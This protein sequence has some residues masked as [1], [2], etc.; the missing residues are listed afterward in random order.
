MK[1]K[2]L[3][4]VGEVTGSCTWCILDSGVQFLVDCGSFQGWSS[5]L[6]NRGDFPFQAEDIRFVLLTHAHIDH[7]GRI[8]LLYKRGFRGKVYCTGATQ[9]LT[10]L[11]LTDT[12][13]IEAERAE[14][15]KTAPLFTKEDVSKI[16]FC[17]IKEHED[18]FKKPA[19]VGV[20][21]NF[22]VNFTRSSHLLGAAS[23]AISWGTGDNTRRIFFSGDVGNNRKGNSYQPLL[24][25]NH[26][27]H[28][29]MDYVVLESTYGARSPRSSDM[30]DPVKRIEA[31]K[32]VV[33]DSKYNLV[34]FP[35][36][37][38]QRTQD[39]LFDLFCALQYC[40]ADDSVKYRIVL[41]SPMAKTA[42]KIFKRHLTERH[43]QYPGIYLND[44][45]ARAIS[46]HY[47][48]EIDE[49]EIAGAIFDA[50]GYENDKLSINGEFVKN[51]GRSVSV[52]DKL[53]E[54]VPR[55]E[56]I[57]LITSSGMCQEGRIKGH[58]RELQY[59]ETALVLTGY[60]STHNGGLL[61][62]CADGNACDISNEELETSGDPLPIKD[63]QGAVFNLG[64]YY[65]GHADSEDLLRFLF[66]RA[67]DKG[68][69]E[70][71]KQVV[72]FLNHGDD[73]ARAQFKQLIENRVSQEDDMRTVGNV[74]I[75]TLG[76]NFYD[77]NK[78]ELVSESYEIIQNQRQIIKQL[79]RLLAYAR[80]T[81]PHKKKKAK[82]RRDAD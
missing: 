46:E 70:S 1:V 15:E 3:G 48:V 66:E 27:P 69:A 77:L 63:I 34:I 58:L 22:W 9:D 6:K 73:D 37:T 32:D 62:Q 13:K 25:R 26:I 7:C 29:S 23:V 55:G 78:N 56:K 49:R 11:N 4:A 79:N 14:R 20:E 2:F 44:H 59:P 52:R 31:L 28:K 54:I 43:P 61:F 51:L 68:H 40:N 67:G 64:A 12:A 65:S 71:P 5:E 38:L 21:N 39:V 75:P 45:C 42:T 36:F 41:D 81:Q 76:D 60:Q 33:C 16:E 8:P 30:K 24:K 19:P 82:A 57:I 10:E 72:V 17:A 53:G 18:G 80:T 47:G 74:V 35:C 50:A